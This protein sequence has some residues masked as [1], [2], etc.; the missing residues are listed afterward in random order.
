VTQRVLG[1]IRFPPAVR[2][3]IHDGSDSTTVSSEQSDLVVQPVMKFSALA[4]VQR[5]PSGVL[6]EYRRPRENSSVGHSL[7]TP[8]IDSGDSKN[9][10]VVTMNPK[11]GSPC[12]FCFCPSSHL[13]VSHPKQNRKATERSHAFTVEL[14]GHEDQHFGAQRPDYPHQS[15]G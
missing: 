1:S 3:Q 13:K 2:S 12:L 10:E 11:F 9:T 5:A 14:R 6:P 8:Q 4:E 15:Q 7:N